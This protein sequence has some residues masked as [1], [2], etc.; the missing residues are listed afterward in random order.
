MAP[1]LTIALPF[2]IFARA[3]HGAAK[4]LEARRNRRAIRRLAACEDR[5]LKDIGLSRS[6]VMG[7]LEARYDED[8]S[9][10]LQRWRWRWPFPGAELPHPR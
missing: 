2:G 10:L 8:P 5:L 1:G 4:L 6:Q 9:L 3:L 7:A